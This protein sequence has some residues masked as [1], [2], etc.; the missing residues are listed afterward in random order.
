MTCPYCHKPLADCG[1]TERE[2][3]QHI[4]A[5]HHA[6]LSTGNALPRIGEALQRS[7]YRG[8]VTEAA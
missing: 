7:P 5:E 1:A 4:W 2:L 6:A 3:Y 8:P